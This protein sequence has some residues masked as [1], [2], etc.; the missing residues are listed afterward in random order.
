[1]RTLSTS[2]EGHHS[3]TRY[4]EKFH[5]SSLTIQIETLKGRRCSLKP[6][7]VLQ[8]VFEVILDRRGLGGVVGV[9]TSFLLAGNGE[10]NC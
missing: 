4:C 7:F 6:S 5:K 2:D 3:K 1:M 8:E 10:G 9:Y